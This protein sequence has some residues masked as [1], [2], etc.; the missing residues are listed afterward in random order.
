MAAPAIK[1]VDLFKIAGRSISGGIPSLKT[2]ITIR[3]AFCRQLEER[4]LLWLEYHPLS[5]NDAHGD[6]DPEVATKYRLPI[7]HHAPFAI[8]DTFESKPH[9]SLPDVVGTMGAPVV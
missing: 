7:P 5:G 9:H 6:S 3:Q 8:G 1:G 4:F 2:G